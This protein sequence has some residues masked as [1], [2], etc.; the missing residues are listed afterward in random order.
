MSIDKS[1]FLLNTYIIIVYWLKIY[2]LFVFML[3]ILFVFQII[4]KKKMYNTIL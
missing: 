1:S 2:D 3:Y 4:K